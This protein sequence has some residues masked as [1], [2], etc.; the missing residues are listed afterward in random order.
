MIPR[1]IMWM[2]IGLLIGVGTWGA[3]TQAK[4]KEVQADNVRLT[5]EISVSNAVKANASRYADDLIEVLAFSTERRRRDRIEFAR[6]DSSLKQLQLH[7]PHATRDKPRTAPGL[8][9]SI[10]GATRQ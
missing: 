9:R 10:M 1:A 6:L 7:P 2:L 3:F 8:R 5:R 4:L